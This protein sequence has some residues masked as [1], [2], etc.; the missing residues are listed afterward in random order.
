MHDRRL[1]SVARS[2]L[3]KIPRLGIFLRSL[4]LSEKRLLSPDKRLL[5][6]E[7]RLLSDENHLVSSERRNQSFFPVHGGAATPL[8]CR[9]G[10]R[11]GVSNILASNEIQTPPLPLPSKGGE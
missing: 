3:R 9:G 4:L 7:N 2:L 1:L 5:S 10:V 11:G 8:P 6:D